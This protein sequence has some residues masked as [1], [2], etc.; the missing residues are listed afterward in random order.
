V[1][2]ARTV[3]DGAEGH[4]F[5]ADLDLDSREGHPSGRRDPRVCLSVGRPSKTPLV[6]VEPKRGEHSRW[7][8]DKLGLLLID[9]LPTK[10]YF[11][12]QIKYEKCKKT[13]KT[14][15]S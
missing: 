11:L 13:L 12:I 2:G 8:K 4:L 9:S 6:D 3:C 5:T 14:H 1:P 7:R 15:S 10:Y